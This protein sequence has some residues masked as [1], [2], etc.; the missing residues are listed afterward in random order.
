MTEMFFRLNGTLNMGTFR[1]EMLRLLLTFFSLV[2]PAGIMAGMF[3]L[4]LRHFIRHTRETG[5][6]M[7]AAIAAGA[8]GALAGILISSFLLIPLYGYR[9]SQIL[10]A[11]L[12]LINALITLSYRMRAHLKSPADRLTHTALMIRKAAMRFRKKKT[13]LET[14]AKLTR[15]MIRVYTFQGFMAAA[16]LLI[17]IRILAYHSSIKPVYFHTLVMSVVLAGLAL[18]S[19]L[20]R[21]IA[22][23][24][25]NSFRPWPHCIIAGIS[26][27]LS[28]AALYVMHNTIRHEAAVSDN[29]AGLLKS[30]AVLCNLIFLPAAITGLSLPSP[31]VYPYA[32]IK[33]EPVLAALVLSVLSARFSALPLHFLFSFRLP[34]CI[35]LFSP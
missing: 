27:V 26:A 12:C 35:M 10:G 18:G 28:Y 2:I 11:A 4:I 9:M 1:F 14:G 3:I 16:Y 20:Y 32:W 33:P 13:V 6:F 24:P 25:A 31:K 21:R 17:S 19:A 30:F 5:I 8:T 29:F 15:A 7:S 23:K 34:V 22:D